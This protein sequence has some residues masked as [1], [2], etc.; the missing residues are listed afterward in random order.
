MKTFNEF[1]EE[2]L[3]ELPETSNLNEVEIYNK[4]GDYV[5]FDSKRKS[6]TIETVKKD[7]NGKKIF[8]TAE[9]NI[10]RDTANKIKIIM[11]DISK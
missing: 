6:I 4:N 8:Q 2:I 7:E 11:D 9:L 3:S 1:K 10:D 5:A